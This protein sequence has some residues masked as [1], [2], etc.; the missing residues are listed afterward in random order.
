VHYCCLSALIT[1]DEWLL[2]Y[3]AFIL[4]LHVHIQGLDQNVIP[5]HSY[6]RIFGSLLAGL[7]AG[8]LGVTGWTGFLYYFGAHA[9]VK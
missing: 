4:V 3:F 7:V 6:R 8:I 2:K 9:L 1:F 5:F